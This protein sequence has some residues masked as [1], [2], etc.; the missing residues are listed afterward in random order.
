ME[1]RLCNLSVSRIVGF[2]ACVAVGW[3]LSGATPVAAQ[4]DTQTELVKVGDVWTFFRGVEEPGPGWMDPDFDDAGWEEGE[5]PFGYG[6]TQGGTLL[7]D[8]R[9]GYWSVYIRH[10]FAVEDPASIKLL[11]LRINYDDGFG[12]Y[13]NGEEIARRGIT[14][15]P[16]D[17]VPFDRAA[18]SHESGTPET[19]VLSC[20]H[21]ALL[22]QG[23]N[24]LAIQ[25]HN[26]TLGSSDL[27]VEPQLIAGSTICPTSMTCEDR[28][29]RNPPDVRVRWRRPTGV[30]Y[31]AVELRRNG[32]LVEKQPRVTSSIYTDKAPLPGK[33][34]YQIKVT[35]CDSV[36][37]M[38]CSV[39]R[40]GGIVFRRGDADANAAV[41]ITD[42][43]S[44]LSSLFQGTGEP[45]CLDAADTDDNGSMNITDAVFLL[46]SLF[47]GGPQP[48]DPGPETCGVDPTEDTLAECTYGAGC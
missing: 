2:L 17:P 31:E 22:V 12:A 4:V 34:T 25:G 24:V 29:E 21:K 16:G 1:K 6:D 47:Q 8:M 11:M 23:D 5:T 14:G 39:I 45:E 28:P 48:L 44:I 20:D 3:M 40:G 13:L 27:V 43:V 32:V 9:D 19:M 33:N 46:A 38:E 10:L 36:C 35:L 15:N 18:Q 7:D 30:R 37:E 26:T 41:N 42:A